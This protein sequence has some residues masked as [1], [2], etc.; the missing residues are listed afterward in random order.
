MCVLLLSGI[1]LVGCGSATNQSNRQSNLTNVP[2]VQ[3]N[4]NQ[5]K[6]YDG[7]STIKIEG[8]IEFQIPPTMEIQSKEFQD[9]IRQVKPDYYKI[10]TRNNK[11]QRIVVQQKG[12]NDYDPKAKEKYVRAIIKIDTKPIS[13]FPKW[14]EDLA[15][16]Y[17]EAELKKLEGE[18]LNGT[19]FN[20]SMR[21]V[22]V[23]QHMKITKVNDISCINMEYETQL[24]Q[25]PV[26]MNSV[27]MFYNENKMYQ[28]LIMIRSTEYEYWTEK[29]ND[30]RN[31]IKT[32][33]LTK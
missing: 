25:N 31:I 15:G 32:V 19:K 6:T 14:G 17:S 18:L 16:V 2:S 24:G 8:D 1:F 3:T 26:V 4:G 12:L 23:N 27:Y 33:S 21:F 7:W 5:S 10:V 28:V 11:L 20:S 30:V 9:L 22:K 13:V 29:D